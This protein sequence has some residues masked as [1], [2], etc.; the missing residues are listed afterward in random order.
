MILHCPLH[1]QLNT[2]K[3]YMKGFIAAANA[4]K[5]CLQSYN[6]HHTPYTH[7][8]NVVHKMMYIGTYLPILFVFSVNYL[9]H[10]M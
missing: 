5:S 9:A 10:N 3:V 7:N 1:C 2:L 4:R 8:T 6:E